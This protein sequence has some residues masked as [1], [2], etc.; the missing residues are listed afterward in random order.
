MSLAHEAADGCRIRGVMLV[1]VS[2]L[3]AFV[4]NR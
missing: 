2:R 3:S 1:G 4:L